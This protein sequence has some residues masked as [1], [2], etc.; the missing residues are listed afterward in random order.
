MGSNNTLIINKRENWIDY[1]KGIGII[2]VVFGHSI[3]ITTTLG[4]FIYIFHVPL[5]FILSGIL[6]NTAKYNFVT[7]IKQKTKQ[8]LIP[9]FCFTLFIVLLDLVLLDGS[10]F[11]R[12]K[13]GLPPGY[14]FLTTLYFSEL[15][16]YV[17]YK[18]K[19][20][21]FQFLLWIIVSLIVVGIAFNKYHLVIPYSLYCIV[22]ATVFLL[23]GK[24]LFLPIFCKN[25]HFSLYSSVAALSA[26]LLVVLYFNIG[27]KGFAGLFYKEDSLLTYIG[28]ISGTYILLIVCKNL[29]L[30]LLISKML[31]FVGRNTVSILCT[32]Y[33]F[34]KLVRVYIYPCFIENN[35]FLYKIVEQFITWIGI[36]LIVHI[37]NNTP[38]KIITG[39]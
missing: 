37:I 28:A 13:S 36:I 5:F 19:E 24:L 10:Y 26:Y 1:A 12:L 31:L 30:P 2:L 29:R 27:D 32:H 4:H 20:H 21:N 22:G 16:F 23:I 7:F 8:L 33:F 18:N 34:L 6:I 35:Y 3:K 9:T 39:R 25:Y 15:F 11:S 17:L 14:W 38:L